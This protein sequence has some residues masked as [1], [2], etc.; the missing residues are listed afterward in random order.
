M[1]LS[2]S[3]FTI[4]STILRIYYDTMLNAR[5]R[6][7]IGTLVFNQQAALKIFD[8]LTVFKRLSNILS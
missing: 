3:S 5:R 4:A 7:E 1:K 2:N 8:L 6:H